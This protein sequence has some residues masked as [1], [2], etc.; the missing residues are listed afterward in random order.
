MTKKYKT[1]GNLEKVYSHIDTALSEIELAYELLDRMV[2]EDDGELLGLKNSL[3]RYNFSEL[4][5][6]K[7]GVEELILEK[8][9]NY[10]NTNEE[11]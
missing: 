3:D 10:F 5:L 2:I 4:V 7:N 9:P 6:V 1:M 8:D 11:V